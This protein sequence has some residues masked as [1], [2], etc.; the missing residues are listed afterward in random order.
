MK[1][2][3]IT[4]RLQKWGGPSSWY[5]VATTKEQGEK[6]RAAQKDK[7]RR[8]FGSVRVRARVG[9]TSFDTS[10][11]PTKDGPYLLFIKAGVRKKEGLMEK[12]PVQARCTLL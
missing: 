6:L 11:F 3:I 7:K 8:G 4:A 10:L 2:L 1:E 9:E 5:Y 12:S